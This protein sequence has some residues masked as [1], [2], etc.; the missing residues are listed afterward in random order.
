MRAL[1]TALVER[2]APAAIL[3]AQG[4]FAH[5][6][7]KISIESVSSHEGAPRL[8]LIRGEERAWFHWVS[9]AWLAISPRH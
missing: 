2:S 3:V 9:R 6:G 1:L 7:N 4:W 8:E 5:G